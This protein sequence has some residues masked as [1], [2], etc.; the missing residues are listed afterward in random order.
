MQL[1]V[2]HDKEILFHSA[3]LLLCSECNN[4]RMQIKDL[5]DRQRL[6]IEN[7]KDWTE[8]NKHLLKCTRT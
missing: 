4:Q 6:E 7:A 2:R 8:A 3:R 1:L 5:V